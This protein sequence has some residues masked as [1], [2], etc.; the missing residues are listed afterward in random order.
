MEQ[1]QTP[2]VQAALRAIRGGEADCVVLRRDG[3]P[4]PGHGRGVRP[5][6]QFLEHDPDTLAGAPSNPR[7]PPGHRWR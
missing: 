6:L 2:G 1:L 4:V 3:V 7:N 5:L